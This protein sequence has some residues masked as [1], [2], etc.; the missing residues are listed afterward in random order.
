MPLHLPRKFIP[1]KAIQLSLDDVRNI[2]NRLT[3]QLGEQADH[4][5]SKLVKADNQTEADFATYKLNVREGAFKTTVTVVGR[6]GQSL[7]GDDVAVFSYALRPEKISNIYMTNITAYEAFSGRKPVNAF[8]LQLDFSKPP[9]LDANNPVS[10]PTPNISSLTVQGDRESWIA[11][12]VVAVTGVTDARKTRR[13]WVHQGFVYDAGLLIVGLPF[14]LYVC[15][16]L[17][18]FISFQFGKI[19]LFLAAVAY[20]Y[21]ILVTLFAYRIL[22]GYTKWAFPT[23]ELTDNRDA[24][25]KHRGIW[26]VII[27]SLVINV[28]WELRAYL[29]SVG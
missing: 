14:A 29:P 4:E 22:F 24:A 12:V 19:H 18:P 2:Y 26:S 28:L 6:D 23:L 1:L 10:A 21:A 3:I 13:S 5:L 17:S 16:K 25:I 27:L 8:E 11:A 7:F 15:W 9:L 20:V